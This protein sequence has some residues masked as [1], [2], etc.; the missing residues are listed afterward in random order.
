MNTELSTVPPISMPRQITI[1]DKY[2]P[3]MLISDQA[4]A[5]AYFEECVS[6]TMSFGKSR[7]EA[8]KIEKANLGYFAGYY[9]RETRGRVERLFRCAHPAWRN[10][11][12][13]SL[14]RL[15]L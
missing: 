4:H 11:C 12:T 8:E 9:S 15:M 13:N 5:D 1:G 10:C 14:A 6:H 2:G 3:A 7:E